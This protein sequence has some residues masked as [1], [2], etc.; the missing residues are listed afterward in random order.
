MP[1]EPVVSVA[2]SA[3]VTGEAITAWTVIGGAMVLGSVV[4]L[5]RMGTTPLA[6]A[7]PPA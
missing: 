6:E 7:A 4:A 5:S 3:L 2:L 1:V